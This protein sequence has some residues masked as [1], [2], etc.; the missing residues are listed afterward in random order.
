MTRKKVLC[1]LTQ[2][3]P[4]VFVVSVESTSSH[5]LGMGYG[6]R[7]LDP[8]KI[9]SMRHPKSRGNSER[10][11]IE[12][13]GLSLISS[14]AYARDNVKGLADFRSQHPATVRSLIVD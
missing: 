7:W 1:W 6:G 4:S 2:S 12:A 14:I 5:Y 13:L 9:F 8:S 10:S 11:A 3:V